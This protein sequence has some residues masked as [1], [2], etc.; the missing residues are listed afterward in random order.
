MGSLAPSIPTHSM[1]R[2]VRLRPPVLTALAALALA[3]CGDSGPERR[4]ADPQRAGEFQR[5]TAAKDYAA[6]CERVLAPPLIQ[7]V[8]QIG[9]PCETALEKGFEDVRD[10][11]ISVGAVTVDGDAATAQVRS[12]AAGQEPSEDTVRLVRVDGG[13]RIASLGEGQGTLGDPGTRSR[14]GTGRAGPDG[15]RAGGTPD[16]GPPAPA[17]LAGMNP[18]TRIRL[19]LAAGALA[20]GPRRSPVWR[21]RHDHL[22]G[23]HARTTRRAGE[24]NQTGPWYGVVDESKIT[25][26]DGYGISVTDTTGGHCDPSP[27]ASSAT[28][29]PKMIFDLGDG[30]DYMTWSDP[31]DIEYV[32]TRATATTRSAA[33]PAR[34]PPACARPSTAAPERQ[35]RR[36]SRQRRVRGGEGNDEVNG[37]AGTTASGRRR[38]RHDGRR[39]LRRPMAPTCSTAA[40][41]STRRRTGSCPARTSIRAGDLLRRRRQ[42]RAAGRER[43]PD[44]VEKVNASVSGTFAAAR[45]RTT[46][47]SARRSTT[48]AVDGQRRGGAGQPRRPDYVETIDGGPGD[49]VLEGGWNNDT[50]TGGPGKDQIFGDSSRTLQLPRLPLPVRQR[51]DRRPR[52]RGRLDRLR[53]RRRQGAGRR[54]RRRVRLR[55][56]RR[57]ARRPGAGGP[58]APTARSSARRSSRARRSRR[59]SRRARLR[60]G[61]HARAHADGRQAPRRSSARSCRH[62]QG[63]RAA[64][65]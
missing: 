26:S 2:R 6:L 28:C 52:R 60:L 19:L 63:E 24:A 5:A 16:A 27:T 64:A 48:A 42:R 23:R 30:D 43:Q 29:P 57:A 40:P 47:T 12:S 10:P 33:S 54:D 45:A 1:L 37:G 49:D 7:T 44:R 59:A 41:A 22:E 51:H 18:R 50:L 15:G 58:A 56:R 32:V 38:R 31:R 65:P 21:G 34:W 35:A 4:G 55:E 13:W 14:P 8:E 46:S 20:L 17:R 9:L 39:R 61:V 62:G 25:I 3:G 53:R 11:R 36:P